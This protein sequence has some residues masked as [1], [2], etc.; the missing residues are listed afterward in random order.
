VFVFGGNG[1]EAP[2]ETA[3]LK[4]EDLPAFDAKTQSFWPAPLRLSAGKKGPIPR[5]Y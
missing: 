1:G 5:C 3:N 2:L 4:P